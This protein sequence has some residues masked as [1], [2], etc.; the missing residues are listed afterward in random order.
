MACA[1][2]TSGVSSQILKYG[3]IA[4]DILRSRAEIKTSVI[5]VVSGGSYKS[6]SVK[7][8][9]LVHI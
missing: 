4:N 8:L 6:L 1:K 7:N 5:E 3:I 9:D 2:A